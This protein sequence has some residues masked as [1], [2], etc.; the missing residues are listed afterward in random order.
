MRANIAAVVAAAGVCALAAA[1]GSKSGIEIKVRAWGDTDP[2]HWVSSIS[3]QGVDPVEVEVGV[4]FFRNTGYGF[5]TSVHSL[6]GSPFS[7][8]DGD[9]ASIID[10]N[11]TST[12]HPDG[13]VGN[14]NFGGQFQVV[15]HTGTSGIDAN[16]FRIAG[17]GNAND[18]AAGGISVK[19]N[20]PVAHGTNFD[21]ADGVLGYHYKLSLARK[22]GEYQRICTLDAPISKVNNYTVYSSSASATA[23][24]IKTSLVETVPAT[25]NITWCDPDV[26]IEQSPEDQSLVPEQPASF[27]VVATGEDIQYQW[28]RNGVSLV[29]DGRVSGAT[30]AM[31][32][33]NAAECED[34]GGYDCIVWN[35]CGYELSGVANLTYSIDITQ[36]PTA[37]A[38]LLGV[39]AQFTVA[40]AG[41][42]LTY[43]WRRDLV[44]LANG[45]RI[46]GADTPTLVIA[47]AQCS[48]AGVYDCVIEDDCGS[49]MS[50]GAA[51]I[52]VPVITQQPPEVQWLIEG[53]E[54]EVGVPAGAVYQYR[55]R[56]N[57]QD[58]FNIPG[59]FQGV[60]TK[61][62]T[63]LSSDP[64]IP[65]DFECVLTHVC[66]TAT[67][68]TATVVCPGD[69][70][71]NGFVNGDDVDAFRYEFIL[72]NEAA[73]V[74]QNG[75]VNGDDADYFLDRFVAGC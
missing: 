71:K 48:D 38:L 22:A 5:S 62:L 6:Y 26:V 51:L 12:L 52:G 20:T 54:L 29:D 14:F 70:D 8:A 24:N 16:R 19:Q 46:S 61:K 63:I 21:T 67:S 50:D 66:G 36:Q 65:G 31:L 33:I 53:M 17:T 3:F 72:G 2:S 43:R 13:R 59:L 35:Q 18:V 9:V 32:T 58:L 39:Q 40:A 55:W 15:Y 75:F 10:T 60:T 37:Q 34:S 7:G 27:V 1:Q 69:F 45:G 4:F 49:A 41:D 64:S 25:I 42:N 68:A 57:G 44:D 23:T 47:T 30:S 56:R 74:D 73:D 11:P 28:R